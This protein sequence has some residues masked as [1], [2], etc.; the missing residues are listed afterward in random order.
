[1]ACDELDDEWRDIVEDWFADYWCS[2]QVKE[3]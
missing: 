2:V 3:R 1:L